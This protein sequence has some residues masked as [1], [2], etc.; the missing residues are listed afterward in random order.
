MKV[1]TASFNCT[2]GLPLAVITER[3]ME[4]GQVAMYGRGEYTLEQAAYTAQ[5]L[6]ERAEHY[7][8]PVRL[9]YL[10]NGRRF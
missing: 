4:T 5:W 8:I 10:Y 1:F 2:A 7:P 3:C 9:E 6:N